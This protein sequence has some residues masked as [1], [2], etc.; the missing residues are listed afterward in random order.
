M[1]AEDQRE[2]LY[3][4]CELAVESDG[5][6]FAWVGLVHDDERKNIQPVAHAGL[7][8]EP[9]HAAA[10]QISWSPT[11]AFGRGPVGRVVWESK[12][13]LVEDLAQA[14]LHGAMGGVDPCGRLQEHDRLAAGDQGKGICRP[15]PV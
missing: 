10:T 15:C 9:A 14:P 5:Y 6:Q 11:S 8:H 7:L 12:P 13:V 1:R 3:Q 4:I 2:L